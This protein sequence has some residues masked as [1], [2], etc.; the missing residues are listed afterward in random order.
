MQQIT[1]LHLLL[2]S[3]CFNLQGCTL[4]VVTLAVAPPKDGAAPPVVALLGIA[5]FI[6]GMATA[7]SGYK[8]AKMN[9]EQWAMKLLKAGALIFLLG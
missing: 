3:L 5:L 8:L 1:Y 7:Y 6:V 2:I 4:A 9:L